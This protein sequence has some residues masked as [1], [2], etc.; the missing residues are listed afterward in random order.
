MKIERRTTILLA[1]FGALVAGYMLTYAVW[2]RMHEYPGIMGETR[3]SFYE[4]P[5]TARGYSRAM[6]EK[7][8]MR[9]YRLG[10][11]FAPLV[12]VDA[13]AFCHVHLLEAYTGP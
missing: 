8:W 5:M 2:S 13:H 6:W 11:V 10:Q 12:W 4:H 1:L 9:E 7:W 3:W